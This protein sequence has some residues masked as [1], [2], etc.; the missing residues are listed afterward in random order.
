MYIAEENTTLS[1]YATLTGVSSVCV[2]VGGWGGGVGDGV[3]VC[4]CVCVQLR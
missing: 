4:V 3:C 1:Q 2:G